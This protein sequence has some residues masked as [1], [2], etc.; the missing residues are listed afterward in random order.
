MCRKHASLVL[1]LLILSAKAFSQTDTS[2]C[3]PN[4]GFEMGTFDYWE[5]AAGSV[6]LEGG[7]HV[8]P[9]APIA[10]RHTIITSTT[11]YDTYGNFPMLCPYGSGKSIQLGNS[12][13]GHEA[14]S[15]SYTFT[16][17]PNRVDYTITYYYAA[18]LQ[19]PHHQ[20]QEQP[21]FVGKMY[22]VTDDLDIE[23][24]SFEFVAS[25]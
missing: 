18:V 16:I 7:V 11:A 3:P 13:T 2:S 25:K 5:C 20:P 15:V 17:P 14:E 19:T 24:G 4:I 23:C 1:T 12:Q 10:G 22:N 8:T 6:D 9:T 21:R